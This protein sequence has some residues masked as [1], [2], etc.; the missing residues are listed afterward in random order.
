MID[1]TVSSYQNELDDLQQSLVHMSKFFLDLLNIQDEAM[2]NFGKDYIKKST[3]IDMKI[4]QCDE[5]IESLA[6]TILATRQPLAID[7]R[8]VL[9]SIKIAVILERM[10]D[11]SKNIIKRSALVKTGII[12]QH[13]ND[14]YEMNATLIS[15]M[16]KICS[17]LKNWHEKNSLDVID[18]DSKIDSLYSLLMNKISD[19]KIEERHTMS[20]C[21]QIVMASK[22][23][24]RV[25]DYIVKLAKILFYINT[26]NRIL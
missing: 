4:N 15:M 23:I 3:D 21:I 22:N 12:S 6:T 2:K 26:G 25:G 8:F 18:L 14:I 11:L 20:D 5:H 10:G 16:K 9:S 1:H 7:L 19:S 17:C 13:Q 24:E